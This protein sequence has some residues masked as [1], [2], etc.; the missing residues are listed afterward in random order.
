MSRNL[1]SKRIVSTNAMSNKR[2]WIFAAMIVA[3]AALGY[4]IGDAYQRVRFARLSRTPVFENF[5]IDDLNA[6]GNWDTLPP[7][8]KSR[9][10]PLPGHVLRTAAINTSKNEW[11]KLQDPSRNEY[12]WVVATVL[13]DVVLTTREAAGFAGLTNIIGS[14][15]VPGVMPGVNWPLRTTARMQK[16][17][18][19]QMF[20]PSGGMADAT[21]LKSV[22]R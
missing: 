7:Q 18:E 13:K 20:R 15:S 5:T 17:L 8:E 9:P 10:I 16:S 14:N 4:G 3:I 22:G 1:N 11:S 6:L 2:G 12:C 19:K 21:D